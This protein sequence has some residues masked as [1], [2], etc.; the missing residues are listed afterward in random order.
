[1]NDEIVIIE[2]Q[3]TQ[4]A[5][6][7][8]ALPEEVFRIK[9]V[10]TLLIMQR[11]LK[12]SDL[13]EKLSLY[14]EIF[15][16]NEKVE[17][18]DISKSVVAYIGIKI[19]VENQMT[20]FDARMKRQLIK[21]YKSQIIR[22]NNIIHL[23]K[24]N[25]ITA[26]SFQK[27]SIQKTLIKN[28]SL[29]EA[30]QNEVELLEKQIERFTQTEEL[31]EHTEEMVQEKVSKKPVKTR[32]VHEMVSK[33]REIF[34]ARE[35]QKEINEKL[36]IEEKNNAKTKCVEI[37]FYDKSLAVTESFIC[38]DIPA[39]SLFKKKNNI[40]FGLSKNLV[41]GVYQNSDQ[42]LLE[43]TEATEDF[44]QFMKEDILSGEFQ[45]K[46]FSDREKRSLQIYFDFVTKCF[47]NNIG[48][49]VSVQEYIEFKNYYNQAVLTMYKLDEKFQKDL[50]RAME[51]TDHYLTYMDC[52]GLFY[53]DEKNIIVQNIMNEQSQKYIDDLEL[54]IQ[55]HAVNKKARNALQDLIQ[56]IKFF[57]GK[58]DTKDEIKAEKNEDVYLPAK[59]CKELN[60]LIV[61]EHG[62]IQV[63][64]QFQN[65]E[66]II[67][68]EALFAVSNLK[69][70]VSD[71]LKRKAYIKKIGISMS[72]KD[73]FLYAS[74]NESLSVTVL[75]MEMKKIKY[76]ELGIQEQ[77]IDFYEDQIKNI[78]IELT[79]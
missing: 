14:N 69:K 13:L 39:Y 72:G 22:V 1:M 65:K 36:R 58:E 37:P 48:N 55:H 34:S 63:K 11:R 62:N 9:D 8:N 59:D 44:I 3:L 28:E 40:Y 23:S 42:S 78:M 16:K 20:N 60:A 24:V 18:K 64:I 4:M 67:I 32:I 17:I 74:K 76:V 57:A 21:E 68:D 31:Q 77:L 52:Y 66:N 29:L 10:D 30:F 38:K 41:K 35:S 56:K 54:I 71:Y 33:V 46:P 15:S 12:E 49:T 26:E 79:Q 51:L 45:M 5:E 53:G 43:L 70:A 27:E 50:Y 19:L 6:V 2:K 75:T 47:E 7:F 61:E 25:E 73:V